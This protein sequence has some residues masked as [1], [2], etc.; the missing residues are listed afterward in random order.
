VRLYGCGSVIAL[1]TVTMTAACHGPIHANNTQLAQ[2]RIQNTQNSDSAQLARSCEQEDES[3]RCT[4][5]G[6]SLIAL[7]ARPELY[8]GR[9]V[10]T[11]GFVHFEFEGNTLYVSREDY[12]NAIA[13]N[14]L[15]IDPP[16]GFQSSNGVARAQ[17][18]DRYVI[19]E[20]TF[21]AQRQGHMG[22]SSGAL[23][24]VSRLDAWG[25][26][27]K[28]LVFPDIRLKSAGPGK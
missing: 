18:N 28:P 16:P 4:L 22:M 24:H 11:V 7:I 10:R 1:A 25:H 15:W 26:W 14:G 13:K 3:H 6:P 8:D 20:A 17:P 2:Q 12:D 19:V 5:W 27:P 9:R 23:E 21:S